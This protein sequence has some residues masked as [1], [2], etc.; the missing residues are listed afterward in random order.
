MRGSM[1]LGLLL[2]GLS[3]SPMVSNAQTRPSKNHLLPYDDADG[4]LVMSSIIDLRTNQWKTEP[5]LI[6]QH[7]IPGERLDDLKNECH[8]RVPAEFQRAA[9]D[10]DTKAKTGFLLKERFSLQKKYMFVPA[11]TSN[12]VG[13]FSVSPVGFDETKTHAFVVVQY[14]VRPTNS[15]LGGDTTFYLLRKTATGWK[16]VT[17]IPKCGRIY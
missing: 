4:Y 11:P 12:S 17:E 16:E 15:I 1:A 14:L 9:E 3:L 2:S 8:D 13:V 10:F 7:T 6:F 5:V